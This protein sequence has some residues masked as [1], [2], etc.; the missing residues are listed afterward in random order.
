M[1]GDRRR[2]ALPDLLVD[3]ATTGGAWPGGDF[4]ICAGVRLE[5]VSAGTVSIWRQDADIAVCDLLAERYSRAAMVEYV[6]A[7][8]DHDPA[9]DR[10]GDRA[11]ALYFTRTAG[12]RGE[13]LG[14]RRGD[15]EN[16]RIMSPYP[17]IPY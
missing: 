1:R 16:R 8:P 6:G 5:R 4:P 3:R 17:L 10:H 12:R 2:F 11:G 9:S 14:G 15:R 13:G 7:D